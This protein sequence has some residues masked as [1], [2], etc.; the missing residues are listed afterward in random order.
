MAGGLATERLAFQLGLPY[1]MLNR[2]VKT[3]LAIIGL[4]IAGF[5]F[6]QGY[7]LLVRG[8]SLIGARKVKITMPKAYQDIIDIAVTTNDLTNDSVPD[9]KGLLSSGR[10]PWLSIHKEQP[11]REFGICQLWSERTGEVYLYDE[12]NLQANT[13]YKYET[14]SL[15][16]VR[17]TSTAL[18]EKPKGVYHGYRIKYGREVWIIVSS[19]G[20]ALIDSSIPPVPG[21]MYSE[22]EQ[23]VYFPQENLAALR[24]YYPNVQVP[25]KLILRH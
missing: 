10:L 6:H 7:V 25:E 5:L 24:K 8:E 14:V 18:K 12:K 17:I 21:C 23:I 9:C 20:R 19:A 4:L 3:G 13:R 2:R 15:H 22:R 11:L 1:K 16:H